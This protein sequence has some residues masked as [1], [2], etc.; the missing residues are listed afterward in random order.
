MKKDQNSE[1]IIKWKNQYELK[2]EVETI[3]RINKIIMKEKEEIKRQF[4]QLKRAT[5]KG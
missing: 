3:K 4:D 2:K 1:A 5:S